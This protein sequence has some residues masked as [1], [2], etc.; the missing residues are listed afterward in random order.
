MAK[1]SNCYM[2]PIQVEPFAI[3]PQ[4]YCIKQSNF[5]LCI[6]KGLKKLDFHGPYGLSLIT[7]Y[8]GMERDLIKFSA[9]NEVYCREVL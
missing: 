2:C 4:K 6:H 9:L 3:V 5:L 8:G 1:G 7:K